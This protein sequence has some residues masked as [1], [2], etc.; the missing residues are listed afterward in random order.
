LRQIR[1]SGLSLFFS[2]VLFCFSQP[3]V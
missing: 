2:G 1:N 3:E